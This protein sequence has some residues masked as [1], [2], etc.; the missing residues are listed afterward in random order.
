MA[1]LAAPPQLTQRPEHVRADLVYDFDMYHDQAL[2][3]DMPARILDLARNAPPIFWTPHNGGHWVICRHAE[4]FEAARNWQDFSSDHIGH[5]RGLLDSGRPMPDM[6]EVLMPV[7]ILLD[8]PMHSKFRAPLNTV[9]SPRAMLALQGHVR[10]LARALIAQVRQD[11][12]CEFMAA[13]AEPIP[14][15]IF[16]EMFGLPLERQDEFRKLVHDHLSES[17]G[18]HEASQRQLFRMAAVMND[19]LLDRR[20]NPRD[21]LISALWQTQVD[22]RPLT[23]RD[24]E[25][26]CVLL[27]IAGLDTVMNGMG[28]GIAYLAADPQLQDELRANPALIVEAAEELLRRFTFLTVVRTIGRDTVFRG[29]AMRE[30]DRAM[31][32]YPAAGV[33]EN[34]YPAPQ[35]FDLHRENKAHFAF[36]AGPHRCVGSHLARIE[37]QVVYEEMLA[38]LPPFRLDPEKP[39]RYRCGPVIGPHEVHLLW[40]APR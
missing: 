25:N 11:G 40:D 6:S 12:A 37:L 27:F 33:D 23:L 35:A 14:V 29:I 10:E 24:M 4:V 36:G 34:E 1:T 7:P 8:P 17:P 39:V 3:E 32:C 18:D 31:L 9:L 20:D 5:D 30:G 15:Q 28:L 26:Y 22:G 16:L 2:V 38:G 19:T 21:D 13:I